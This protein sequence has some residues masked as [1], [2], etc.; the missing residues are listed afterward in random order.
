MKRRYLTILLVALVSVTVASG[1]AQAAKKGRGQTPLNC[2]VETSD[3]GFGV[4]P[5]SVSSSYNHGDSAVECYIGVGGKDADLVTYNTGRKLTFHFD[6]NSAPW[7]A[8]GI[9]QDF[10]AEV[11]FFG[12]N[13]FGRYRDM[14]VGTTAQVQADLEFHCCGPSPAT[15]ELEYPS[16]AAKRISETEWLITTDPADIGGDP[17][18]Q[19]SDQASLNIIRRNRQP[20]FGMVNMPFRL[21]ITIQ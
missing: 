21:R 12:I 15:Y 17:G 13:Y 20:S 19:A 1:S 18:F 16:L 7:Q 5:D 9:P 11:D 8:S 2:V 3:T 14:T 6:P 10:E 4:F